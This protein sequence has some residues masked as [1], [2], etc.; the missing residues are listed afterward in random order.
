MVES[1]TFYWA[2]VLAGWL[3]RRGC[4]P[5]CGG[6]GGAEAAD[7]TRCSVLGPRRK[8][9][10]RKVLERKTRINVYNLYLYGV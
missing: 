6:G 10:R 4:V 7:A 1:A 5:E 3:A 2:R 8:S 9:R